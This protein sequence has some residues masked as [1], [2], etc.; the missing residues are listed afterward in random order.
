MTLAI[1]LLIT[2]AGGLYAYVNFGLIAN[3]GKSYLRAGEI[4]QQV[5]GNV[6][7]VQTIGG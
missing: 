2:I 7:A 1:V 6:R 4:T 3:V 5:I